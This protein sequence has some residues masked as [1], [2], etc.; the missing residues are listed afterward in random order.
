[1]RW[2]F[3]TGAVRTSVQWLQQREAESRVALA[4]RAYEAHPPLGVARGLRSLGLRAALQEGA[5]VRVRRVWTVSGIPRACEAPDLLSMLASVTEFSEVEPLR[6]SVAGPMARW[7]FRAT[8]PTTT[9][10]VHLQ[11]EFRGAPVAAVAWV[12]VKPIVQ[13]EPTHRYPDDFTRHC[14]TSGSA[15]VSM[16][17]ASP[18]GPPPAV[19]AGARTTS[20][21]KGPRPGE[22]PSSLHPVPNQGAGDCLPASLAQYFATQKERAPHLMGIRLRV[23]QHLLQHAGG[24]NGYEQMWDHMAPSIPEEAFAGTFAEYVARSGQAG[25]PW[26]AL[27]LMAAARTFDIPIV[28]YAPELGRSFVVNERSSRPVCRLLF[29]ARHWQFLE[30]TVATDLPTPPPSAELPP[31]LRGA[32]SAESE[33][34]PGWRTAPPSSGT[35]L[36]SWRTVVS[37]D[38]RRRPIRGKRPPPNL[39][40]SS[41][42]A[43]AASEAGVGSLDDCLP[44]ADVVEGAPVEY[45]PQP[46]GSVARAFPRRTARIW[47]T[48]AVGW[49]CPL[50]PYIIAPDPSPLEAR[51]AVKRKCQHLWRAHRTRARDL[52]DDHMILAFDSIAE[53]APD[54]RDEEILWKCR[55]CPAGLVKAPGLTMQNTARAR[56]RHREVSHPDLPD[57][58]VY[59]VLGRQS[60]EHRAHQRTAARNA[61]VARRLLQPRPHAE[62]HLEVREAPCSLP[63]GHRF[64]RGGA[65]RY[66]CLACGHVGLS[67]KKLGERPCRPLAERP[68]KDR[69]ARHRMLRRLHQ[70]LADCPIPRVD[71]RR[72]ELERFVQTLVGLEAR[73]AP[74][75]RAWPAPLAGV[76]LAHDLRRHRRSSAQ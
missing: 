60:S 8:A 74:S 61:A 73:L 49:E 58:V 75:Q 26:G 55:A 32:S 30:G 35:L 43:T 21:A 51:R 9:D 13:P 67:P 56:R 76:C 17:P 11:L 14:G 5:V 4:A 29:G 71:F 22:P 39:A 50:C 12:D 62:H 44:A 53:L 31:H 38:S 69:L 33:A 46:A 59:G 41:A 47:N 19:S 54:L 25:A 28:V 27:E 18:S 10:M 36:H 68:L 48:A 52:Y 3:R 42:L 24:D 15:D 70:V 7:L 72:D 64:Y 1:M 66:V 45:G 20:S 65:F 23:A 63:P 6:R 57:S 16:E 40:A 37:S 2:Y 34:L